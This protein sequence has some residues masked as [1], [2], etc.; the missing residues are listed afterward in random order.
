MTDA[1]LPA[2]FAELEPFAGTL[3]APPGAI[4]TLR[5]R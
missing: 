1:L 2:Q 3:T 4:R 5:V